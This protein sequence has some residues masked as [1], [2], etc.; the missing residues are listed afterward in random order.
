MPIEKAM[1]KGN[2]HKSKFTLLNGSVQ[3][4]AVQDHQIIWDYSAPKPEKKII[5]SRMFGKNTP[6]HCSKIFH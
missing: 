1:Q 6:N 2:C 3:G 4:L 5:L